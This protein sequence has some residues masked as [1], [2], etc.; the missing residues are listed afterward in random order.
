MPLFVVGDNILLHDE[1]VQRGIS[2]K[3]SKYWLGPYEVISLDAVNF[4]LKLSRNRTLEVHAN[5]LKPFFWLN[6]QVSGTQIQVLLHFSSSLCGN[7]SL[8]CDYTD[9]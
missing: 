3:L 8:G 4:T 6:F 5:R 2:S 9:I 7:S 1:T